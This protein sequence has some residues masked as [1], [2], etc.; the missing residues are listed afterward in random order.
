[1][2]NPCA[3]ESKAR[4][5][6]FVRGKL[7]S[8]HGLSSSYES[9]QGAAD[10]QD[11]WSV[12]QGCTWL[13]GRRVDAGPRASF[14][15]SSPPPPWTSVLQLSSLFLHHRR[16]ALKDSGLLIKTDRSVV[17]P[18]CCCERWPRGWPTIRVDRGC[19]RY[20][21]GVREFDEK[22]FDIDRYHYSM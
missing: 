20:V 3:R 18:L 1:M 5:R 22:H 16:V 14:T 17:C 15:G 21:Y 11:S 8:D 9:Q 7:I 19:S 10:G 4:A 6:G 13:F 12:F 2:L